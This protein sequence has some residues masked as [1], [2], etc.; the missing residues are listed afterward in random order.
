[1]LGILFFYFAI[2]LASGAIG[3]DLILL[4][5]GAIPD[6]GGL[7]GEYWRLFTY[8]LLHSGYLHLMANCVLL[9]W[10]GRIVEKRVGGISMVSIYGVSVLSGGL[11]ITLWKSLHP[12]LSV[13]LGASDGVFGLLSASLVLLYR[14]AAAGFRQRARIRKTLWLILG[15][16]IVVSFLPGISFVGHVAGLVCGAILGFIVPFPATKE[17]RSLEDLNQPAA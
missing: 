12:T 5:L 1:M 2:E 7:Q 15:V 14:P 10:I 17:N 3:N 13:S 16:G 11:I 9:W 6:S 4:H 8:S